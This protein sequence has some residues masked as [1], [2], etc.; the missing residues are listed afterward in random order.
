MMVIIYCTI[1]RSLIINRS[2]YQESW[3]EVVSIDKLDGPSPTCLEQRILWT[4]QS[5]FLNFLNPDAVPD[6]VVAVDPSEDFFLKTRVG[7]SATASPLAVNAISCPSFDVFA[8]NPQT[9]TDIS[10]RH[11]LAHEKSDGF[12]FFFHR[13]TFV[14]SSLVFP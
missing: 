9:S 11:F 8:R 13:V 7:T 10:D 1:G 4:T 6:L 12:Q 2:D 14:G 5:V 3:T